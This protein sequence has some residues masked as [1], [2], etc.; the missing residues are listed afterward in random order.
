MHFSLHYT[1]S[2]VRK[3]GRPP[4]ASEDQLSEIVPVRMTRQDR[5]DCEHAAAHAGIKLTAWIRERA[6]MAAKR[7]RSSG[8]EA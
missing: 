3:L 6:I 2:M 4:K 1:V 7:V 5:R 8:P